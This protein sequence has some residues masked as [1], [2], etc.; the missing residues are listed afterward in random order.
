MLMSFQTKMAQSRFCIERAE[1]SISIKDVVEWEL[2]L[3]QQL[4]LKVFIFTN[5]K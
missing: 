1:T 5:L 4:K 2:I 3:D